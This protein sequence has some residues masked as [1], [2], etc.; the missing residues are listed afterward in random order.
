[1]S[2]WSDSSSRSAIRVENRFRRLITSLR[3]SCKAPTT[4]T[5]TDRPWV[6]RVAMRRLGAFAEVPVGLVGG[7]ERQLIDQHDDERER[8][9]L[10]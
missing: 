1:M 5:P 9:R 3:G 6:V 2:T 4:H 8:G 10:G 7:Q